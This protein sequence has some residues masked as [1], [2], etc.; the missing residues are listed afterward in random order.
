MLGDRM[1][2]KVDQDRRHY[3]NAVAWIAPEIDVR[4]VLP[5][6]AVTVP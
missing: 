6:T 1:I 4:M 5:G 2:T 3:A